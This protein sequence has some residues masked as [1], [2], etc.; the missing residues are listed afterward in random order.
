MLKEGAMTT[1]ESL[2]AKK[3]R[4]GKEAKELAIQ[5][6]AEEALEVKRQQDAEKLEGMKTE[7][8]EAV[9]TLLDKA[10]I[11]LPDRKQVSI[12]KGETGLSVTITDL[13]QARSARAGG[14]AKTITYD[15][16]QIS[17]QQLADL[18]GIETKGA[19]AHKMILLKDEALHD[20]IPHENCP[21]K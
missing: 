7:I 18:K 16:K 15:G 11:A 6:K 5:I 1:L 14:G 13:K 21:Y 8:G 3:E 2:K 12:V 10:G 17:W 9:Q 20:S 4:I 19:S